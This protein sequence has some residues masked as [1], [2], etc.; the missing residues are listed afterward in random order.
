MP[1]GPICIT[2]FR[3]HDQQPHTFPSTKAPNPLKLRRISPNLR[4]RPR[5][6]HSTLSPNNAPTSLQPV[7]N[8]PAASRQVL[9]PTRRSRQNCPPGKKTCRGGESEAGTT[10]PNEVWSAT[11]SSFRAKMD[12][13]PVASCAVKNGG[14]L[15]PSSQVVG[16]STGKRLTPFPSRLPWGTAAL[17]KWGGARLCP[18]F[19]ATLDA[20]PVASRA[21]ETAVRWG[22]GYR[23]WVLPLGSG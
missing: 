1:D 23:W 4:G 18:P 14:S 8:G 3:R 21:D 10:F 15:G 7:R 20:G 11:V 6:I 13:G 12:A 19:R 9:L 5:R 17:R 2:G 22:D 16:A